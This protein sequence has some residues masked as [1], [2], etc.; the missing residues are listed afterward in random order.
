MRV[1]T[2]ARPSNRMPSPMLERMLMEPNTFAPTSTEARDALAGAPAQVSICPG[3]ALSTKSLKSTGRAF[4]PTVQE[5]LV[6][7]ELT[8][9]GMTD[10][11]SAVALEPMDP[12]LTILPKL[13]AKGGGQ[14]TRKRRMRKRHAEILEQLAVNAAAGS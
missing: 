10:L 9:S 7:T 12:L 3:A 6:E 5:S 1:I 2:E 11:T 8:A 4:P 14:R 13:Q